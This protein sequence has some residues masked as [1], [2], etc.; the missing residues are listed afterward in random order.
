MGGYV[1]HLREGWDE[2]VIESPYHSTES[3][4]TCRELIDY[5]QALRIVSHLP[6]SFQ[7]AIPRDH[8][9]V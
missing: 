5:C 6:I 9:D 8:M 2:H 3:N 1:S 7:I 4:D